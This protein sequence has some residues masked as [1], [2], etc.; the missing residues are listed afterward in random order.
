MAET[1]SAPLARDSCPGLAPS[2]VDA[3]E[4]LA[5]V[6]QDREDRRVTHLLTVLPLA[7]VMIAGPQI[8]SAVFLATSL[9][10]KANS[11]A[12]LAGVLLTVTFFVSLAYFLAKLL[13]DS[14]G[15]SQQGSNDDTLNIV[16]VA[17]LTIL[18]L[19]VFLKRHESQPPKWMG[20]LQSA[21]PKFSFVLGL[22]LLGV[23]PTD[24]ITSTSV[25][26]YLARSGDPWWHCLP[27]VFLTLFLIAVPALL[28]IVLGER[29]RALLPKARDWMNT[30]SWLVSEFVIVFFLVITI[31]SLAG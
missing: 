10:W 20:K 18:A 19:R 28:V 21:T 17:L 3:A 14:G 5:T 1:D 16:I 6:G 26:A 31:N 9:N 24:I 7:F 15:S 11:T 29:G 23:F 30:H 12:F 25:G 27:F 8:I 2:I 22:L 13:H 4:E